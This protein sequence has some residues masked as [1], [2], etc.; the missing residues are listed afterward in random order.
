MLIIFYA[1][2]TS[3]ALLFIKFGTK[4]GSPISLMGGQL[5][6][7][8]NI[9]VL[10]GLILFAISFALWIY[11]V[12]EYDL[13]YIVPISTAL[14]YITIFLGA[15]FIFK[16]AFTAAKIAGIVL[17]FCGIVLLNLGSK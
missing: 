12:S 4:G 16:E 2:A 10:A 5:Q 13:S 6:F 1:L 8:F 15:Y 14:V 7:N 17:I 11:L 9:H 3:A